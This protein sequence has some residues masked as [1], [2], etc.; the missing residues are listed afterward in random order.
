MLPAPPAVSATPPRTVRSAPAPKPDQAAQERRFRDLTQSLFQLARQ[1]PGGTVAFWVED[2]LNG[3]RWAL[4]PDRVF[5]SASLIKIP[6]AALALRTWE[7]HPERRTP[8][9]AKRLWRVIAESH[10]VSTDVVVN[11]LGG[12]AP[13]NRY[14]REHGWLHTRMNHLMMKW[15][16]QGMHNLTT[17]RDVADMLRAIDSDRLDDRRVSEQM[18]SLLRDQRIVDRIP[19]G[20]PKKAGLLVGNKTGTMLSVVHDAAIVRGNG[21]RYLLVI[22]IDRPTDEDPADAYC[23]NVSRTVY[24]ALRPERRVRQAGAG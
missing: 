14:C 22:M 5:N 15:Q 21:L 8:E 20:L 10:N 1:A 7:R 6:I 23:R 9:L 16:H 13:V 3:R 17:A 11:S 2:R 4:N 19:A 12:L 24:Q 18:W